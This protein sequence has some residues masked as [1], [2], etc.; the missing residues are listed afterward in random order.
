MATYLKLEV[1]LRGVRPK[2]WRRFLIQRDATFLELHDTIQNACGWEDRHF[3]EFRDGR[4]KPLAISALYDLHDESRERLLAD[5]VP[6]WSFFHHPADRCLYVYDF[7][8]KWEHVIE[9]KAIVAQPESFRRK[10]LGGARAFPLENC[11]GL[12]GYKECV[13]ASSL[14]EHELAALNAD[15]EDRLAFLRLRIGDWNP[16]WFD[17]DAAA[18]VLHAHTQRAVPA[19]RIA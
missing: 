17:F 18:R 10:L 13:K 1:R 19:R 12:R 7:C 16:E 9:L 5:R 3:Y 11:G 15:D 6:L 14:S 8:D 2:I 4:G